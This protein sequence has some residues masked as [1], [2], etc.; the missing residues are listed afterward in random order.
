MPDLGAIEIDP[1]TIQD[2]IPGK[3]RVILPLPSG[4]VILA[5]ANQ[6]APGKTFVRV[7]RFSGNG[8]IV[9]DRATLDVSW[10]DWGAWHVTK[11]STAGEDFQKGNQPK[12]PTEQAVRRAEGAADLAWNRTAELAYSRRTGFPF[13]DLRFFASSCL[14][15]LYPSPA[16]SSPY[17]RSIFRIY[18]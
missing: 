16:V 1:A 3:D 12:L 2:I 9:P 6:P 11:E 13:V 7:Q 15:S 14:K 4:E 8:R 18:P 5:I 10:K 17:T